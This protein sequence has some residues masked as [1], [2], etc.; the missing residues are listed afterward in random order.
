MKFLFFTF[1]FLGSLHLANEFFGPVI[2]NHLLEGKMIELSKEARLK[3]DLYLVKDLASFIDENQIKEL[4]PTTIQ[5]YHPSP[6]SVVITARYE[7][8]RKF[9]F[10]EKDYMFEP[11]SAN[12]S[13]GLLPDFS[14]VTAD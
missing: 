13:H 12:S 8:Y 4:D 5:V 3:A 14:V 1:L 9:W 2:K 11:S 6:K 7:V 10:L